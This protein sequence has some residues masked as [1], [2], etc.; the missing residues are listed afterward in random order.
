MFVPPF[1]MLRR[2]IAFLFA[3][4]LAIAAVP[5]IAQDAG[6]SSS[7]AESSSSVS[8]TS[9]ASTTSAS[10]SKSRMPVKKLIKKIVNKCDE[11]HGRSR[12]DCVHG[13]N[14]GQVVRAVRQNVRN[15]CAKHARGSEEF[16]LCMSEEKAD[17]KSTLNDYR[18]RA[19]NV[20]RHVK[21]MVP[22][23]KRSSSSSS[24]Q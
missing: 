13:A 16:R 14:F 8:S 22:M 19:M 3:G 1:S 18:P 15:A 10:S 4:S 17:A 11:L 6:S 21:N 7:A 9:S 12:A 2:L 20:R 24:S 23:K 5:V